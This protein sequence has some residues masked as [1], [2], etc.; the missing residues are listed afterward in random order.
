MAEGNGVQMKVGELARSTG[1]TV[2]TLHHYDEIGLLKPSGRS[3]SGYRLYGEADVARLH[4]IQA[5]RQM[6]LGLAQIGE[7]F[8][9][10]GASPGKIVEQQLRALDAEIARATELRGRLALLHGKFEGGGQPELDAW[11]QVLREMATYGKYFSSDEMRAIFDGYARLKEEWVQVI[12]DTQAVMDQGLAPDAPAVQSLARRWMSLMLAWMEGDFDRIDR[13]D[14]MYDQEPYESLK[15]DAPPQ[16]MILYMRRAIDLRWA[17]TQKYFT[18]GELV[19]FR[20]VPEAEWLRVEQA[21]RELAGRGVPAASEEGRAVV[22][23]WLALMQRLTNGN[24]ALRDK[25]LQVGAQEPL[26]A[27]GSPLSPPV[28][29][30]LRG[31]LQ[32]TA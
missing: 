7:L 32:R 4:G 20:H 14:Q 13:W 28:R 5:L 12:A 30:W 16:A 31:V 1:L 29:E 18:R 8:E 23:R 6:G 10:R 25:L 11:L 17:V 9:G 21:A 2:R 24:D 26:L 27:A 3:E 22:L 19:D 15:K